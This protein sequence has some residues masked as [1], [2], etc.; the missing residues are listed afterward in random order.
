MLI[1]VG[2]PVDSVIPN[3]N[4]VKKDLFPAGRYVV[5]EYLGDYK[6]LY[7]V[8]SEFDKWANENSIKF[9][10]ARIEFYPT[11]PQMEKNPDKWKT[12]IM[13]QIYEP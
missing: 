12:I 7:E 8:H 11:D 10:G 5:L 2:V 13:N 1:K 6:N 9:K 4:R 3:N